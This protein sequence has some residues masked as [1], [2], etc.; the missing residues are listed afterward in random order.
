MRICILLT[1]MQ[2]SVF[3]VLVRYK[4]QFVG[5][6]PYCHSACRITGNLITAYMDIAW[7]K[8]V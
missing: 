6:L 1:C 3:F 2:W 4:C 7:H 8:Y 5:P